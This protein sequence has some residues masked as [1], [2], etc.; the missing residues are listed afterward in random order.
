MGALLTTR[1][2]IITLLFADNKETGLFLPLLSTRISI[3]TFVV[4]LRTASLCCCGLFFLRVLLLWTVVVHLLCA[5]WA[6][7]IPVFHK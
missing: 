4:L 7:Y 6:P 1:I 3:V 5:I 2:G